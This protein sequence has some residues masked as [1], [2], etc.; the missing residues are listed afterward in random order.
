MKKFTFILAAILFTGF[1][2]NAQVLF[3]DDFESY[4]A[5]ALVGESSEVW[6]T[7]SGAGGGTEDAAV[8]TV[9]AFSGV[10]S[11]VVNGINDMV[12]R[13]GD[14]T[15]G[16]YMVSFRMYIETGSSA[17]FNIQH[18]TLSEWA[19]ETYLDDG[20]TAHL[21]V[22]GQE[23]SFTYTQDQWMKVE[24]YIDMDADTAFMYIDGEYIH[25]WK[26]SSTATAST[27]TNQLGA[28]NFYS[29][30]ETGVPEYYIDDVMFSTMHAVTFNFDA[31]AAALDAT[32]QSVYISGATADEANGMGMNQPWPLP[33]DAEAF[34][35]ADE[36]EDGTYAVVVPYV[37]P[38]DYKYKYFITD[39]TTTDD[40]PS[41]S[42][43]FTV[44]DA[45]VSVSDTWVGINNAAQALNFNVYPNPTRGNAKVIVDGIGELIVTNMLGQIIMNTPIDNNYNLDLSNQNS[46]I[47]FV[48]ART[49]NGTAT[50][51]LVVE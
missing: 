1:Y 32:T 29:G 11:M 18:V 30:G 47:Y 36:E 50:L 23:I 51:R 31:T 28:I 27:G 48:T 35:M 19:F 34:L 15:S 44:T 42:L 12:L 3:E 45:D 24:N 10:N 38:G 39:G 9:H 17:Y 20:G 41:D 22:A 37:V 7:W 49:N 14:S 40:F 33:G 26:F 21:D 13:F 5:D 6:E 46:G 2:A 25:S 43:T 4:T 8:S 16:K